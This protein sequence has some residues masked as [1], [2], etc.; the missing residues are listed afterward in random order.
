MITELL[1]CEKPSNAPL[2]EVAVT[3]PLTIFRFLI[4]AFPPAKPNNPCRPIVELI[5]KLAILCPLPLNSPLK[6]F[7]KASPMGV[8][9]LL[10]KA[11]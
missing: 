11:T 7:I 8:Q 2:S 1:V 10:V 3:E 6:G 4:L 5:Y 9:F